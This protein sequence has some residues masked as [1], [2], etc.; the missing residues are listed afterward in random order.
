MDL[1]RGEVVAVPLLE[2]CAS[3]DDEEAGGDDEVESLLAGRI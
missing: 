3:V 2:A 1:R